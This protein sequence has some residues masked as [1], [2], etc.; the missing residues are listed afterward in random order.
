MRGISWLAANQLASQEGLCTVE[1]VS[2]RKKHSLLS[3]TSKPAL[4][5]NQLLIQRVPGFVSSTKRPGCVADQSSP[6]IV[7]VKKEW[8]CVSTRPT[9]LHGVD[10][11][12][13]TG[14]LISPY[15][16]QEGNKPIFLSKWREF[17]SAPCLEQK[18]KNL[19]IALVSMLSKS[20]AS[21]T[22]FRACLLPGRAKD[23]SATWYL[24][25]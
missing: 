5:P 1:W 14:V 25:L 17:P 24:Y 4:G 6:P 2:K 9:S 12:K 16:D 3:V 20:R 21:L 19:V 23:L 11:D 18:K 7:G 10:R 22:C 8:S 15:P 13:Y